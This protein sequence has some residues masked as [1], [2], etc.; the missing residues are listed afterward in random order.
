MSLSCRAGHGVSS[1]QI[2]LPKE[3]I[4]VGGADARLDVGEV[5]LA[6]RVLGQLPQCRIQVAIDQVMRNAG[7]NHR[8]H[9]T[10]DILMITE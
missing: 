3:E 5:D 7:A 9:T 4:F 6:R 2:P 8:I 1:R 10:V